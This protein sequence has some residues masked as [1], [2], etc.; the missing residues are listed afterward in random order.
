MFATICPDCDT[1]LSY[2]REDDVLECSNCDYQIAY[3]VQKELE[4]YYVPQ[5]EKI[6]ACK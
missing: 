1:L 4:V 5:E 6:P 2:N 3:A